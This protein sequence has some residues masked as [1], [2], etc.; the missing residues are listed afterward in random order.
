MR[1]L[2][3]AAGVVLGLVVLTALL[4]PLLIPKDALEGQ[5]ETRASAALGRAVTIEGPPGVRLFP[6][7]LTVRGL[8]VAN[9]EGFAEPYFLSVDEAAV[10]VRLLPLLSRRVEITRFD[11]DAP[12][13]RL[14][15]DADGNANWV[16]APEAEPDEAPAEEGGT[17]PDVSLGTVRIEDGRVRY[18][19]A[20]GRTYEAEDTDVTIEAPSLDEVLTL[21]GT[22]SVEGRPARIDASIDTPRR[23]AETGTGDLS[24]DA[25]IGENAVRASGAL[26]EALAFEGRLDVDLRELRDLMALT[27]AQAPEAG[28]E[29]LALAGD[30]SGDADTFRFAEGTRV[31]FDEVEGTGSLTVELGG[32]KPVVTGA[33]STGLLDLRPYLPEAE[34][35]LEAEDAPFPPWS[36]APIDLSALGVADADLRFAAEAIRLPQ[37]EVGQSAARLTLTN[38]QLALNLERMALYGGAGAGVLRVDASGPTPQ[39]AARFDLTGVDAGALAADAAGVTRLQGQGGV[40]LDLTTAGAS[41][42]A[43]VRNLSGAL[44]TDLGE[45]AIRGVNLG[46]IA[47]AIAQVSAGLREGEIDVS[48]L[49][50]TLANA[51]DAARGPSEATDF[52]SLLAELSVREGVV[53]TDTLRLEGPAY[54]VTGEGTVSLPQQTVRLTLSPS[55]SLPGA[56]T[57]TEL[58]APILVSGTFSDPK[59]G[60]DAAPMAR[61][62]VLRGASGV[63]GRVGVEVGE[64]Q[65]VEDAVRERARGELD[66]V[67]GTPEG[68]E[69][70]GRR[71]LREGLGG[72]LGGRR[73][74]AEAGEAPEEAPAEAELQPEETEDQP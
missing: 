48:R 59:V 38:G 29:R 53:T 18:T 58:L 37:I 50:A 23:L 61:S 32:A 6:T 36:E 25:A 5:I 10:G 56:T 62:A 13:I 26:G 68:E 70:E 73:G 42:A 60:V 52:S 71:M 51:A 40:A 64:D 65:S 12:D 28:F 44:R 35:R 8:T 15:A 17:L 27:G 43:F 74:A 2:A 63:L 45:G 16:F 9:A 67:L 30:V 19:G 14:E 46:Q 55:A 3:I 20:D 34:E 21:A 47:G 33:L 39:L 57:R 22:L 24:V 31:A 72:L 11:L 4:V 54:A 69:D 66:R 1:K 41:Q 7:Q 49:A